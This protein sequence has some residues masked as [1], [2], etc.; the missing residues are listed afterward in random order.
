[1]RCHTKVFLSH[2]PVGDVLSDRDPRFTGKFWRQTCE[3]LGIHVSLTS[4]WHPQ[5]DGQTERMNRMAEQV[6]RAHAANGEKEWD[7][8]LSLVEF[9]MNN[10]VHASLQHTPFFLNFAQH[11]ITPV[12]LQTL[13]EDKI[14]CA[15]AL[16]K[17]KDSKAT[18]DF[19]LQQLKAARDRMKSYKDAKLNETTFEVGD[20]V[21]LSTVNINKHNFCRKLYPKFI[22]PFKI[23]AKVNDVA[24]RLDLPASLKIHNVFHVSLLK[25]YN[26]LRS[27]NPPPIPIEVEGELEY[28]VERILLHRER[29]VSGTLKKEYFVKWTG[30]GPEHCTWEPE[31]HLT[32][33]A[34]CIKD[35]WQ[36]HQQTL[37]TAT[38]R[39]KGGRVAKRSTL[40]TTDLPSKRGKISQPT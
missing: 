27:P 32:N 26:G 2:P 40:S 30:Y 8:T 25:K 29:K 22:G 3:I 39:P 35:Y 23:T 11:P 10:S 9:A 33:A 20:N 34:E 24:Y 15:E 38:L 13:I 14:T 28:E 7:K 16:K 17:T 5:S 1:M 18:L 36:L 6:L 19:A 31:I 12:M 37:A 21:L 4:A